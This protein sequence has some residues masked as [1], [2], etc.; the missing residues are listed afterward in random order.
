MKTDQHLISALAKLI[1]AS[2]TLV[3]ALQDSP[4][5][6]ACL[7]LRDAAESARAALDKATEAESNQG[8]SK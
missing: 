2:E 1:D 3:E 5:A 6:T 7:V 8:D 4:L